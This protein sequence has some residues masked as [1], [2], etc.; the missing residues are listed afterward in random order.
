MK[1]ACLVCGGHTDFFLKEQGYSFQKCLACGFFFVDPMPSDDELAVVYSPKANYQSNKLKKDYKQERNEKYVKIFEELKK[2][3]ES[4]QKV[5]DVGTSDGEFL[6]Y[7]KNAGFLPFGVEP[8]KTTAEIA[9]KND[10][11][12]FCGFL[13]NCHFE[14]NSFDVLRLGDV[15]EH[16]NN[17]TKLLYECRTFLKVGGLLIISIPNMDSPWV[18]STY[19]LKKAWSLPWSVLTPPHHLLYFSKHNLDL[20]ME[21]KGFSAVETWY[22]RPPTLKYELGSTHLWGEF[23]RKRNSLSLIRFVFGFG[24]Y[25]I[26]YFF[27]Y[28]MT[29]LKRK[30]FGM[31]SIY[32]KNA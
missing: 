15:L 3:T 18:K 16:S 5:L 9:N 24:F 29:P 1:T 30:D 22:D 7:A 13:E 23:K 4:G 11:N 32:K 2:Y 12:V 20:L 31:L 8:N 14:K 21:K 27:D 10:L 28:I 26:L 19:Y 17:P 25:S 6:Y